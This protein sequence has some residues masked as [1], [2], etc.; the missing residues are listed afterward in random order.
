MLIERAFK[1]SIHLQSVSSL[2]LVLVKADVQLCADSENFKQTSLRQA[3]LG[4]RPFAND[5][6]MLQH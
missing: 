1:E 2:G 3:T 5:A 4:P 6:E